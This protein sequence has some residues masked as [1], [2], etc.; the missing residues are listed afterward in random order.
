MD[1][2][3][4]RIKEIQAKLLPSIKMV[5]AVGTSVS[6]QLEL[7]SNRHNK[8]YNEMKS[9]SLQQVPVLSFA[10]RMQWLTLCSS[11]QNMSS[12]TNFLQELGR[13]KSSYLAFLSEYLKCC[14]S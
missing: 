11:F 9:W 12:V 8:Q 3:T 5:V 13:I 2:T 10:D 4:K 6:M 7:R 1:H 14:I